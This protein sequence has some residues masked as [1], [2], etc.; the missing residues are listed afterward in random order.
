M[1]TDKDCYKVDKNG[2]KYYHGYCRCGKCGGTGK[3][4]FQPD[5]GICYD[6]QGLGRVSV[7]WKEYTP[8]YEAKL[9]ARR[10]R[11]AER[12][13]AKHEAELPRIRSEWLKK[14]GFNEDGKTYLFLED[15]YE[16]KEELKELGAKFQYS[17]GWHIDRKLDGYLFVEVDFKDVTREVYDGYEF[18]VATHAIRKLKRKALD[19][20]S[21]VPESSYIGSI[22]DKLN[23]KAKYVYTYFLENHF[24]RSYWGPDTIQ[25]HKFIDELGN[26]LI[27]KTQ[28]H[29]TEEYGTWFN[30]TGKVKDHDKYN[31]EKQTILTRCKLTAC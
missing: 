16:R 20:I 14:N 3:V 4:D 12:E 17:L 6:C 10:K 5:N 25:I 27:W 13:R 9:E 31:D 30:L 19:E 22:G 8:E 11:K 21:G 26:I 24:S 7:S 1:I 29:I 18:D 15:V 23:V 28:L 2:T